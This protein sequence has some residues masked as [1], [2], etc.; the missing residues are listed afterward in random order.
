MKSLFGMWIQLLPTIAVVAVMTISG[1]AWLQDDTKL[2]DD[3]DQLIQMKT[4][5]VRNSLNSRKPGRKTKPFR[6]CVRLST[7]IERHI[8][9]HRTLREVIIIQLQGFGNDG[10]Y[11]SD[12]LF[13][14]REYAESAALR[15]ELKVLFNDA[16]GN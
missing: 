12:E 11:L 8:R 14:R 7:F 10:E 5:F 3:L 15:N 2:P 16:L 1:L 13:R 6:P 4:Q 9:S